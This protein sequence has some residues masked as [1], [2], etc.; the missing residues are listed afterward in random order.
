MNSNFGR[1]VPS[2]S[3]DITFTMA[4]SAVYPTQGSTEGGTLLVI[5]GAGFGDPDN[6]QITVGGNPCPIYE[7]T[8][9]YCVTSNTCDPK[10]AISYDSITC[11]A[12]AF[13]GIKDLNEFKKGA[14]KT[15]LEHYNQK[16]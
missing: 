1:A 10:P 12:P 13:T 9:S 11:V 15:L 5:S 8:D 7:F 6:I 14:R 3:M 2:T 16:E 4:L